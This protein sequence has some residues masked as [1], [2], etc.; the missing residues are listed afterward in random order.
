[1]KKFGLLMLTALSFSCSLKYA[2]T[3]DVDDTVPELQFS[4]TKITR[5]EDDKITVEM[6]AD[7]LEQY[8]DSSQSYAKNLEFMAYDKEDKVTTE[9]SCG[10]LYA[11]TYKEVYEL[12]SG[13]KLFNHSDK[14]NFFADVLRWNKKTEQLTSGVNSQVRVEKDDT[15]MTGTGFAASGISKTF[16]F[17]G[18]VSGE[19]DTDDNREQN[20]EED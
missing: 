12:Y 3:V 20:N 5:Y 8:K 17:S 15:L 13:I 1:M 11:D 7:S 4:N 2:D 14:T 9:G 6:K 18:G 10:Y 19:I 16:S